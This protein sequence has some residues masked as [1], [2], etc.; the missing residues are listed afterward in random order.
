[1][2]FILP[3]F[4]IIFL[5]AH[6]KKILLSLSKQSWPVKERQFFFVMKQTILESLLFLYDAAGVFTYLHD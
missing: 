6:S 5:S 2:K 1:M 4:K 3:E